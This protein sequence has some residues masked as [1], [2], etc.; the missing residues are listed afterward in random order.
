M[1]RQRE[2]EQLQ[3]KTREEKVQRVHVAQALVETCRA[4]HEHIGTQ[5]E[6][7][8]KDLKAGQQELKVL[9]ERVAQERKVVDSLAQNKKMFDKRRAFYAA[10]VPRAKW[11][12]QQQEELSQKSELVHHKQSSSCPLCEQMLSAKRKHFLHD[13]LQGQV[14]RVTHQ[15]ARL[16]RVLG[17]LKIQLVADHERVKEYDAAVSQI[18]ILQG[19]SEQIAT[20]LTALSEHIKHDVQLSAQSQKKL[21]EAGQ[22]LE[23]AKKE[24]A[25]FETAVKVQL[26]EDDTLVVL[27]QQV[28]ALKK[29]QDQTQYNKDEHHNLE[30]QIAQLEE[31]EKKIDLLREKKGALKEQRAALSMQRIALKKNILQ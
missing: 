17:A 28:A 24:V 15:Y 27:A 6:Q 11:L 26:Q 30:R 25:L 7:R 3:L 8:A 16:H 2:I 12:Y 10:Y 9:D 5:A 21:T 13:K 14:V 1:V 29:K 23:Q 18:Q 22:S 31:Q 20:R 4:E 19:Q